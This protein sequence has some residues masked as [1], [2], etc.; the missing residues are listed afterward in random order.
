MQVKYTE[1]PNCDV[2]GFCDRTDP[3]TERCEACR[4]GQPVHT[5]EVLSFCA[6]DTGV[7][8]VLL[9]DD[10]RIVALPLSCTEVYIAQPE[11][12]ENG[13]LPS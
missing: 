8:V 4:A 6:G 3:Y 7:N 1:P 2:T 5:A 10:W 13:G 11:T 9:R 12:R